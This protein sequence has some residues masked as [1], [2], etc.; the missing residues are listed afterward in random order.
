MKDEYAGHPEVDPLDLGNLPNIIVELVGELRDHA[1]QG[2][3]DTEWMDQQAMC[4]AEE[5]GEFVG[6]YRRWRGF[7]RRAG[8][9]E[10]VEN[11]LADVIVST[12]CMMELWLRKYPVGN[13]ASI[14]DLIATKLNMIFSRGWVN[15]DEVPPPTYGQEDASN[16]FSLADS[17]SRGPVGWYKVAQQIIKPV[18]SAFTTGYNPATADPEDNPNGV[19][20]K[21][22]DSK[23]SDW[24]YIGQA[25][26]VDFSSITPPF[27]IA[28]GRTIRRWRD[29]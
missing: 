12:C 21:Y 14:T 20:V 22:P 18:T 28:L 16:A 15:K 1:R 23:D 3:S 24:H 7:A 13:P 10:D 27:N 26:Q 2:A 17:G 4:V 19:Y 5:A 8:S 29:D 11:E 25:E 6:A 9:P